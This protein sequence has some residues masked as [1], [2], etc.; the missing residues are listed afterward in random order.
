MLRLRALIFRHRR[1]AQL[2]MH[3]PCQTANLRNLLILFESVEYSTLK[4]PQSDAV[5]DKNCHFSPIFYNPTSIRIFGLKNN[6]R[7][8][9]NTLQAPQNKRNLF[10]TR[11]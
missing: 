2:L 6:F 11:A 4:V 10:L 9:E 7:P 5:G 8:H 1:A 3:R